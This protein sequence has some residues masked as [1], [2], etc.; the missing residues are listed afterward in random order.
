[1]GGCGLYVHARLRILRQRDVHPHPT[2][3]ATAERITVTAAAECIAFTTAATTTTTAAAA[4]RI[5]AAT[6]VATAVAAVAASSTAAAAAA[7]LPR[8]CRRGDRDRAPQ[9]DRGGYF[10]CG[11]ASR[12][13]A[14][15]IATSARS[16]Q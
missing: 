6:A 15:R 5:A 1:M 2:V 12:Q 16:P 8:L 13:P 14:S 3:A 10:Y 11:R 9:P 4:E 7:T